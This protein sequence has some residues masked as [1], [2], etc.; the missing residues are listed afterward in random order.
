MTGVQ[1][2]ASDLIGSEYDG[3]VYRNGAGWKRLTPDDGLAGW[4]VKSIAEDAQ[5]YYWMGTE[6]GIT[7]MPAIADAAKEERQ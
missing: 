2:C 1:T 4:E 5:G 3:I 7:R 6:N